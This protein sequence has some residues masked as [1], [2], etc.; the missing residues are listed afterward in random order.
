MQRL[1]GTNLYAKISD[2]AKG[3]LC[4]IRLRLERNAFVSTGSTFLRVDYKV[5]REDIDRILCVATNNSVYAL[6]E[7]MNNGYINYTGGI[8]I[9][10]AGEAVMDK[11]KV[12]SIKNIT[13]IVIRLPF[14]SKGCSDFIE[15]DKLSG[16]NLLIV[17]PP[18]GGKT[19]LLRDITRRLSNSGKNMVVIDERFELAGAERMLD[20][21]ECV[22]VIQGMPKSAAYANA[23]RALNPTYI[24]TDELMGASDIV[25]VADIKRCGIGV[26]AT[27]HAKNLAELKRSKE[28]KPLF[29]V[30]DMFITLSAVPRAGTVIEV[31]YA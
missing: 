22:D 13:S 31:A 5:K 14:E 10:I 3:R 18:Y 2:A 24:V 8:R 25:S 6:S 30:F 4:E 12:I 21:G 1:L 26:I 16:R 19:T 29:D 17:S 20:L 23:V 28:A 7:R 9:G 11:E 15:I 27:I